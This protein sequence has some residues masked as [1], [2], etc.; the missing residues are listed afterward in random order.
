MTA[1]PTFKADKAEISGHLFENPSVGVP[2]GIY[3][4]CNVDFAPIAD[5][6]EGREDGDGWPCTLLCDWITW[7]IRSWRDIDGKTLENCV[8]PVPVE[9]SLYFFGQHQPL[10]RIEL[11]FQRSRADRFR[12]RGRFVADLEDMDG[13]TLQEVTSQFELEG[14]FSG[15]GVLPDNLSPKPKSEAEAIDALG[16]FVD[17]Q[18][19]D[20]PRWE[21]MSWV[22][23][24]RIDARDA[25][26][27]SSAECL[28][29]RG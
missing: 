23:M 24:P 26:D 17:L 19:Y 12:I 6:L 8:G 15:L 28:A 29:Q 4:S 3:Y 22:F 11:S 7:P 20:R 2:R 9:A 25:S 1:A 5:S 18:A 14:R 16:K 10:S 27:D 13:R 21:N